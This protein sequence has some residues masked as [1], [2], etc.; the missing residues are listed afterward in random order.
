MLLVQAEADKLRFKAEASVR[1]QEVEQRIASQLQQERER[2]RQLEIENARVAAEE[3]ASQLLA[4]R[5]A[6]ER[7]ASNYAMAQGS[8]PTRAQYNQS[9]GVP[10]A[11]QE[12]RY[13]PSQQDREAEAQRRA[14]EARREAAQARE[15][16]ERKKAAD[17]GW[18]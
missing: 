13:S 9:N 5:I 15:E 7:A 8:S 3:K 10:Q 2:V 4:E 16:A 17:N 11:P 18:F 6:Q 14:N 12:D 1:Q